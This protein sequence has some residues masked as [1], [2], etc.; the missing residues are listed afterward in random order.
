VERPTEDVCP[1]RALLRFRDDRRT[2]RI[3]GVTVAA[4]RGRDP[5]L[6]RELLEVQVS[7]IRDAQIAIGIHSRVGD[8]ER[9]LRAP[10]DAVVAARTRRE[11]AALRIVGDM[12]RR[13]RGRR[14]SVLWLRTKGAGSRPIAGRPPFR[15]EILRSTKRELVDLGT[16]PIPRS[17]CGVLLDI[18][19]ARQALDRRLLSEAEARLTCVPSGVSCGGVGA[20]SP[21][22]GGRGAVGAA[23]S[24]IRSGAAILPILVVD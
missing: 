18:T 6:E 14:D 3:G 2:I 4:A 21:R 8:A 7:G 11:R 13:N 9:L 15:G 19:S 22:T 17:H 5:R 16:S 1:C 10:A 24:P 23:T 12:C 20:T